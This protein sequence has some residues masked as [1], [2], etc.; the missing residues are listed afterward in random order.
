MVSGEPLVSVVIP[1]YNSERTLPLCLSS[2]RA[3]TYRN[4]EVIVVDSYSR[5]RTLE[6]ARHYGVRTVLTRWKLLGARYLG[7][8]GSRGDLILM[9]DSDQVLKTRDVIERAV[10]AMENHDML[11]LEEF[12]YRPRTWI[13]KLFEADRKLVHSLPH[14]HL[15]PIEGVL[16]ARMYR[17]EILEEAFK[18]IP[19]ELYP[20]VVAHDHAI[21]YYEAYKVSNNVGILTNAVWHI[22]PEKLT[23][24]IKKN[25]R[26]GVSTYELMKLNHSYKELLK[27]KIRLRKGSLKNVK[28]GI[29]S[30][31]LFILKGIGFNI[32]YIATL[33][34]LNLGKNQ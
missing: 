6:I 3:Q 34:H 4:V 33:M 30:G 21:I 8:R 7:F 27:R 15:N 12:T 25:I 31:I 14:I 2:V 16:L 1:T 18:K 17:R 24:L 19:K 10:K 23:E 20:I 5:D 26:Y 28:L 9:L 11:V 32:G 22:E 29:C 13:Q